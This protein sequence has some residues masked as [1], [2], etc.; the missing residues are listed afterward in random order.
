VLPGVSYSGKSTLVAALVK[1]GAT[2]YSDEYAVLD[3]R[4]RVHSFAC[5]LQNRT[6]T[7][8]E[9]VPPEALGDVSGLRPLPLGL[10]VA[11]RY[12]PHAR[13]RP[14]RLSPGRALLEVLRH[15]VPARTRPRDTLAALRPAV[16]SAPV[17]KGA[18]GDAA[19][20][21]AALLET[22]DAMD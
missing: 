1:A 22:L 9:I 18:R 8:T 21:A 10:V 13:W 16:S 3:A 17:F 5:A 7:G 12:A 6:E 11:A 19:E 20:T 2:Y 15:T 4:G 14:R